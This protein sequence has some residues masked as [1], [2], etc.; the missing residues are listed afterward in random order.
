MQTRREFAK[1]NEKP[2]EEIKFVECF[3]KI[4]KPIGIFMHES[5]SRQEFN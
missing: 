4:W 3:A 1:S 5:G 2:S